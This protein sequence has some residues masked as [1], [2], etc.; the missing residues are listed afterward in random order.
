MSADRLHASLEVPFKHNRC[1]SRQCVQGPFKASRRAFAAT[2]LNRPQKSEESKKETTNKE[3]RSER[4]EYAKIRRRLFCWR[5][6]HRFA[7]F[8]TLAR[9]G[10]RVITNYTN[11][12]LWKQFQIVLLKAAALWVVFAGSERQLCAKLMLLVTKKEKKGATA[13]LKLSPRRCVRHDRRDAV[14]YLKSK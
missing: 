13:P 11:R 4:K 6:S 3:L 9:S 8:F 5:R 10:S 2:L 1:D 14:S 7:V 12:T